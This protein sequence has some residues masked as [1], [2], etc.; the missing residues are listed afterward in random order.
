MRK[1]VGVKRKE[2]IFPIYADQ[3]EVCRRGGI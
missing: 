3:A 1:A 2:T